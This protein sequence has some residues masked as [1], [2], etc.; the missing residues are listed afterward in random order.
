M[1]QT[2]LIWIQNYL[3]SMLGPAIAMRNVKCLKQ[4]CTIFE[5]MFVVSFLDKCFSVLSML[6]DANRL[7]N[8]ASCLQQSGLI[9]RGIKAGFSNIPLWMQPSFKLFNFKA[10]LSSLPTM[11]TQ[12]PLQVLVL[13]VLCQGWAVHHKSLPVSYGDHFSEWK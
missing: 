3:T 8:K 13:C 9:S 7:A 2:Q 4:Y 5:N 1:A 11:Q 10:K 6:L 12:R